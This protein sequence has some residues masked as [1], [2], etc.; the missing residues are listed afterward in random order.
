MQID[1]AKFKF[2]DPIKVLVGDFTEAVPAESSDG[3][4]T[5]D[6]LQRATAMTVPGSAAGHIHWRPAGE[7]PEANYYSF[8][9]K[10]GE[11]WI[12]ETEAA[13]RGSPIDTRIDVLTADG[14]P[15]E[16]V[17]LKAVRDSFIN[18]RRLDSLGNSP[19]LK[20]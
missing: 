9:T 7:S 4:N 18:F 16:R 6:S 12:I 5:N 11:N 19:R 2:R 14:R 10:A 17:M 3:R 13:R 8:Q 15:I 20:N 1:A